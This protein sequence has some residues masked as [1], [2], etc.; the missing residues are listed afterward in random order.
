VALVGVEAAAGIDAREPQER[1][2][3]VTASRL[4]RSKRDS[5]VVPAGADGGVSCGSSGGAARPWCSRRR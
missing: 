5:P 3:A 2:E 1:G 4:S